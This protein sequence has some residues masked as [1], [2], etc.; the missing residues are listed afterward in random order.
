MEQIQ[1]LTINQL[2][3]FPLPK[4]LDSLP[5]PIIHEFVEQHEL[6]QGFIK[7]LPEYQ[8]FNNSI[9]EVLNWQISKLNEISDILKVYD[10]T[11]KHIQ[12]QVAELKAVYNEFINLETFQYQLLSSNFNQEFLKRKYNKIIQ[13]NDK[14]SK[15]TVKQFNPKGSENFD[16]EFNDLIKEFRSS[17]KSY[18]MR[19]EKL[20]R[21]NEERVSGFI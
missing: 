3:P 2:D 19:K 7:Q 13:E 11:G 16:D 21:W 8:K 5:V 9:I 20:N 10:D 4:Y 17:R 6:V 18:H 1:P 12:E 15:E 14:Q